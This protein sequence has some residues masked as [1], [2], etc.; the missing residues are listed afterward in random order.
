[1]KLS[2]GL[3]LTRE[4]VAFVNSRGE[5]IVG[6]LY[7]ADFLAPGNPTVI[8]L[9]GNASCQLEGLSVAFLVHGAGIGTL[10]LDL[11]GS[12]VSGG[13]IISLGYYE[14]DDVRSAAAFLRST[15]SVSKIILWGRSMGASLALWCGGEAI[16]GV[17]ASV[18]D[19]P[20]ASLPS[21][22]DDMS[23]RSW[24]FSLLVRC[25]GPLADRA[26]RRRAAIGIDDIDLLATA[27]TADI[28]CLIVH[29]VLDGFITVR[30]SREVIQR[31][32]CPEKY[33]LTVAGDH[34]SQRGFAVSVVMVGFVLR[35]L[36]LD[37]SYEVPIDE[38]TSDIRPETMHYKDAA[39][40]ARDL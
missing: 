13:E 33:L 32:R 10:A 28:P 19:S 8:Y 24:G 20:Y 36:G 39:D 16:E 17:V 21:I 15:K 35:V 34:Q 31:W 6:S 40:L 11:S 14:R 9:H 5:R 22:M 1:L 12:G 30:Q 18:A 23:D 4:P 7:P 2:N 26:I 29:G 3:V 27:Q 38:E 37:L 25:V